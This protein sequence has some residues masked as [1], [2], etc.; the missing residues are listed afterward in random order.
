MTCSSY[1]FEKEK[2]RAEARGGT[3]PWVPAR[4]WGPTPVGSSRARSIIFYEE[5]A[6]RKT[7]REAWRGKKGKSPL[8]L[9][10]TA[11]NPQ[12]S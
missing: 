7:E 11:T 10:F 12:R 1:I 9:V 4:G 5:T 2:K 6:E 8:F 3:D